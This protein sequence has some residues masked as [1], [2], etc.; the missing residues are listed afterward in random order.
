M[1]KHA[2]VEYMPAGQ[3][4]SEANE[5]SPYV[6][7]DKLSC[8]RGGRLLFEQL[9]F[10]LAAGDSAQ[11]IGPNGIGKSSL[12]RL[13]A[14]LLPM[15]AGEISA[16][17]GF[18]LCDENLSFDQNKSLQGALSFW[19]KMS[20]QNEAAVISALADLNLT[21]LADLP[22]RMLSTGQRKRAA[23]ARTITSSAKIWLLDE[24]ANGLDTASLTLLSS[25][26]QRHL[27]GGGIIIAASHQPL[28]LA[29]VQKISLE[30]GAAS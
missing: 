28:D 15:A 14:G 7:A 4:T 6:S 20:G 13:I 18:S 3:I 25:V 12:I 23:L 5:N 21:E 30:Q 2:Y 9:S 27:E 29:N 19:A 24:P 10:S 16:H 1:P 11:I 17:G 26:M 8:I 22:V